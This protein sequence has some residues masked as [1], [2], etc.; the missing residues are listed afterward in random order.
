MSEGNIITEL[1]N[2]V[3]IK[4]KKNENAFKLRG[5][6]RYS[7]EKLDEIIQNNEKITISKIP[8]RPNHERMGGEIKK[9][10]NALTRY[11]SKMPTNEDASQELLSLFKKEIFENPK[12]VGLISYLIEAVT[13][14]EDNAIILD[15][16]AGSATTAE[17]VFQQ[18]QKD[19]ANRKFILIQLPEKTDPNS[20]AY[21][22]R[23]FTISE[24]GKE[25]IRRAIKQIQ[26]M[27]DEQSNNAPLLHNQKLDL[28]FGFRVYKYSQSNYKQWKLKQGENIEKLATLFDDM[29]DPL[30]EDWEKEDLLTEVFLLE[31]F[32][33][34]SRASYLDEILHN[35][36]YRI[37]APEFCEHELFVCLDDA[38]QPNTIE[39]LELQ[40]DDTFICLDSALT[41]ELK[42]RLQDRFNVHVI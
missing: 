20:E 9:M 37:S 14:D 10:H 18:N 35:E 31:G 40:K 12:P 1:L 17:A 24:I 19:Q 39:L 13:Y 41:D 27:C 15:F 21:Q 28:D 42:A 33:L 3:K 16:F 38:I 5:E 36:V 30:I 6:W 29:R 34:T 2:S 26:K 23:L 7:Q 4:N 32:P 22:F 8:F 25:R 11:H